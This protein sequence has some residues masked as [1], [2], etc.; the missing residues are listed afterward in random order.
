LIVLSGGHVGD[1]VEAEV[2]LE[3]MLARGVPRE[4][5]VLEAAST[6]T[7]ENGLL[8]APL[9]RERGVSRVLVVS[10]WFHVP[11]VRLA[12]EQ[13]GIATVAV[14]C[15]GPPALAGAPHVA[16]EIVLMPLHAARADLW[17]R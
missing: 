6:T 14:P 7:R 17:F 12:L 1:H 8:S 15:S 10:Q 13:E 3:W 11:R 16:R 9:L 2:M 4:A 5:I